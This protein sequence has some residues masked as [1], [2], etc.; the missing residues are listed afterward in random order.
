ME[1]GSNQALLSEEK[2]P[3][4]ENP[5]NHLI[6][7]QNSPFMQLPRELRDQIYLSLFDSTRLI[8]GRV[9][10]GHKHQL[11][12]QPVSDGLG[13]LRTCRQINE[14]TKHLWL[15]QV[16]F[17]FAHIEQLLNCL[18]PLPGGTVSQIR[19]I[20][21]GLSWLSV[22]IPG[23]RTEFF[24]LAESVEPLDLQLDSLT[25]VRYPFYFQQDFIDLKYLCAIGTGWRELGFIIREKIDWV[26]ENIKGTTS[27]SASEILLRR[28]GQDT[29]S[30]LTT[31]P[32]NMI[33]GLGPETQETWRNSSAK[34]LRY[35]LRRSPQSAGGTSMPPTEKTLRS[36]TEILDIG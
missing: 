23:Y 24:T 31:S 7:Q 29:E 28:D 6:V 15:S 16:D 21:V 18:A 33:D 11:I 13:A 8:F 19:Y 9:R 3:P 25:V 5:A 20:A 32:S 4:T 34:G 14:E 17:D 36:T 30:Y 35:Q 27:L 22:R 26:M 1:F 10:R 12:E 2:M